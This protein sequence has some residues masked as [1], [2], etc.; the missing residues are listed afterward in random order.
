MPAVSVATFKGWSSKMLPTCSFRSYC[1]LACLLLVLLAA[2]CNKDD[3][4]PR[5]SAEREVTAKAAGLT[6]DYVNQGKDTL[7]RYWFEKKG[8]EA[9]PPQKRMFDPKEGKLYRATQDASGKWKLTWLNAPPPPVV[10]KPE[11]TAQSLGLGEGATD[12][13]KDPMG[14]Y[15][16][17]VPATAADGSKDW[18]NMQSRVY[19]PKTKI[20]YSAVESSDGKWTLTAIEPARP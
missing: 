13:G 9:G 10:P 19:D 8:A 2:G 7:G 16:F 14:R 15:W 3:D 18:F 20:L 5:D 11:Y 12:Q 17:R 4:K 6:D 1:A